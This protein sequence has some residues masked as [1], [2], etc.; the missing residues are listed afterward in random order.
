MQIF[1]CEKN[2]FMKGELQECCMSPAY[3]E[4]PV[5]KSLSKTEKGAQMLPLPLFLP[6]CPLLW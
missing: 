3:L 1:L 2:N 4:F 6:G 5:R